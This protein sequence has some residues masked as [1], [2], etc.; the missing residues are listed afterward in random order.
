MDSQQNFFNHLP[1]K[2][3]FLRE[4]VRMK[5]TIIKSLLLSKSSKHNEQNLSY[6]I[7]SDNF[8]DKKFVQFKT[9]SK[10]DSP[11]GSSRVN[12]DR[13]DKINLT[14]KISKEN[15]FKV[16]NDNTV[17]QKTSNE[18]SDDELIDFNLVSTATNVSNLPSL[19]KNNSNAYDITNANEEKALETVLVGSVPI[20]APNNYNE[21]NLH[22]VEAIRNTIDQFKTL[23][24]KA[25]KITE[26]NE[27]TVNDR[28]HSSSK[29]LED[30]V[31]ETHTW[32]KGTTLIMGD[33][34][35][36][37]IRENKLCKK[38]TIKVRCFPGA[39]FD[40]FYH[41]VISLINKNPDGKV[42]HMG[43]SN[44]PYCTPKKT[45]DQILEL[46]NLFL[47]KLPTCEI[48]I[49]TP[50][51]KTG[52]TT[53]NKRNNLFLNHLKKLNIKLTLN[54]N[55]EKKHLNYRGL[56]LRISGAI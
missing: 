3:Q 29:K 53:A 12:D 5:N 14:H 34:I 13:S 8:I 30:R 37:R 50:T 20:S 46:K 18:Y 54:D 43:T 32:K 6:K 47:Q 26:D 33:S 4:E 49:S 39:K 44:A 35:L 7:T 11:K 45:V 36:S 2:I 19:S 24:E 40:D 17:D 56:H 15:L 1:N 41:Y 38:D 9:R 27:F 51:L 21:V 22:L 10:T 55:I 23:I 25:R 52:N 28:A 31:E 48:I 16:N 42:L